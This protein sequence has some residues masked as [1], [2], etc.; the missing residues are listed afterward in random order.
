MAPTFTSDWF[1][2]HIP[3]WRKHVVSRF[4]GK[5]DVQ[6]L[7]VGSF[8]GRS[9]LWALDNF[10]DGPGSTIA[11]VD[12]WEPTVPSNGG[13]FEATF[14]ANVKGHSNLLKYKDRSRDVLPLFPS[15]YYD[16]AYIDGS[17]ET[18]EVLSDAELV[19]PLLRS[20]ALLIFD[21]YELLEKPCKW[22]DFLNPNA[23]RAPVFGVR[24]AVDMFL[25]KREGEFEILHRGYQLFL[26][27]KETGL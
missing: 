11:C 9:A 23:K 22:G 6:W 7:E 10:L 14:D 24:E 16:G 2:Q 3:D 13:D 12:A 20:N 4:A 25:R 26:K 21:D 1:S 8:E 17:H 15:D 18:S 27:R 19:L 5:P